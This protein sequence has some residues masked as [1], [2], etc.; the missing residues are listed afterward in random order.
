MTLARKKTSM[1]SKV[2]HIERQ[3]IQFWW[4]ILFI[5]FCY[6]SYEQGI[7]RRNIDFAKLGDQYQQLEK[8]KSFA[9]KEQQN[10]TLQL[11]S[12]ADPDWIELSLMKNLG[13]VPEGQTKVMFSNGG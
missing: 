4:V 12:Q 11:N 9:I 13:L 8:E 2:H 7:Q 1:I 3:C 6:Y 10:L 5:L